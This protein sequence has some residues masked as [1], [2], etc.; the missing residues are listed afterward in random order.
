MLLFKAG[1]HSRGRIAQTILPNISTISKYLFEYL[2]KFIIAQLQFS[3]KHNEDLPLYI[4][5]FSEKLSY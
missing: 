3:K 5:K 1:T 2:L 4:S